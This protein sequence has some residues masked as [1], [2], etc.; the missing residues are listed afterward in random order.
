MP[1]ERWCA[2]TLAWPALVLVLAL[3]ALPWWMGQQLEGVPFRENFLLAAIGLPVALVLLKLAVQ[4]LWVSGAVLLIGLL[5]PLTE[6]LAARAGRVQAL[7]NYYGVYRVFDAG[8]QR[9]L[10]HGSTLHGRQYLAGS[11]RDVPLAYFHPTTPAASVLASRAFAFR[12][13]G[14]VGLGTGALAAYAGQGQSF[15]IY[16]L[17]P[18]NL[19]VAEEN[20]GYLAQARRAGAEVRFVFGDGRLSLAKVRDSGLDLLLIDAFNSGAIPAHLLTVE[21]FREYLRVVG[22]GG[23]VLLHVSNK[24]LDLEPIVFSNARALGILACRKTN[25]ACVDPDAEATYWAAISRDAAVA[26]RLISELGWEGPDEGTRLPA[27]WTDQ[28]SN[29]FGRMFFR[30]AR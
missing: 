2:G 29:V 17:D 24:V 16:E 20:F 30:R 11:K 18:D 6:D 9:I 5:L 15:T 12:R 3:T 13:I 28:Y 26:G 8:G 4:P 22:P 21:A 27:P 10:Q 19:G 25:A 7:R 1:Q 23:L 14:M